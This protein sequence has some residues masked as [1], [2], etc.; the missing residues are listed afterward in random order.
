MSPYTL[1]TEDEYENATTVSAHGPC[2]PHNETSSS[3]AM[4]NIAQPRLICCRRPILSWQKASPVQGHVS[5]PS[6]EGRCEVPGNPGKLEQK[7]YFGIWNARWAC[8]VGL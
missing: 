8:S 4:E 3:S 1:G 7:S 5:A 6:L 2:L